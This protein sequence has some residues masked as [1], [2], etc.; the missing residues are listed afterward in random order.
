MKF[1][2]EFL[3]VFKKKYGGTLI[4][5]DSDRFGKIEVIDEKG[6]RSLHFGNQA[7][8]SSMRIDDPIKLELSYSHAMMSGLI[9]RPKP[10]NVL[11]LGLG[12]ASIPKFLHHIFPH[13]QIDT[14]ELRPKVIEV[15]RRFFHV[16]AHRT[17]ELFNVMP[18]SF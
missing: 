13:C 5:E 11:N 8:Q 4:Y 16:P 15:A 2:K 17:S 10:L 3:S 14:V 1:K 6:V 12:G 18:G 7:K 9:F